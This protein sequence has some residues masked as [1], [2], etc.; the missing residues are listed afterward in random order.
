MKRK[1]IIHAT[2]TGRGSQ[3]DLAY[4][5]RGEYNFKDLKIGKYYKI[6]VRSGDKKKERVKT[7]K[8]KLVDV[9]PFYISF[10]SDRGFRECFPNHINLTR[11][12][13]V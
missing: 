8:M 12:K 3:T 11:L 13:E 2:L 10:L 4:I 1:N 5:R 9:N 6:F 7:L